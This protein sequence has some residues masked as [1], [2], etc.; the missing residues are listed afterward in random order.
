MAK[1]EIVGSIIGKAFKHKKRGSIYKVL[2]YALVQADKPITEEDT[3]VIYAGADDVLWAR[4]ESEFKD[5]RFEEVK[6][7]EPEPKPKNRG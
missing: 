6:S 5:G 4:S 2:G 7:D 1:L 3:L